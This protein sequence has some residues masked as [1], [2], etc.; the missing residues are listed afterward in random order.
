VTSEYDEDAIVL[1]FDVEWAPQAVIDDIV[2]EL[3]ARGLKGTFFCTHGNV[4]TPG[5][6]RGLHPNFRR[7]G[8]TVKVLRTQTGPSFEDWTDDQVIRQVLA[9]TLEFCPEANGIRTHSLYFELKLL[10]IMQDMGF[11]YD[12]SCLMPLQRSL[13]PFS[14]MWG[15]TEVPIYYMDHMDLVNDM[16]GF[17]MSNLKLDQKGLKV[18]NFHPALIYLNAENDE[19]Y[20]ASKPFYSDPDRLRANR[21]SGRGT[22]SL[23]LDL[24]D[25]IA[26]RQPSTN[27]VAK[28]ASSWADSN[29]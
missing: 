26:S 9:K 2:S 3:S 18:L 4:E 28:I 22:R 8:E 16:T 19:R 25:N 13:S 14:T 21:Y 1:T 11:V 23:F 15:V 6:E 20:Q 27:T 17:Q 10:A 7:D 24:L 12:S 5:H 29:K